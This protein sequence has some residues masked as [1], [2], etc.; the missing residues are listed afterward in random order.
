MAE[1]I[2]LT[3]S[4]WCECNPDKVNFVKTSPADG[5]EVITGREWLELQEEVSKGSSLLC[6]DDYTLED[7]VQAQQTAL[8]GLYNDWSLNVEEE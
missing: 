7:T 2:I 4:G 3:F 6:R 5:P 1:K 8:D